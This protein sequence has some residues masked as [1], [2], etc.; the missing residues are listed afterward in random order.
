MKKKNDKI[1]ISRTAHVTMV[2]MPLINGPFSVY[3]VKSILPAGMPEYKCFFHVILYVIILFDIE[4]DIKIRF[5]FC[6]QT[7]FL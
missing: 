1:Y 2:R 7:V 5:I 6:V 3:I 4:I